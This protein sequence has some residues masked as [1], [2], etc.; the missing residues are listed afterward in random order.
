MGWEFYTSG[1][2]A[3]FLAVLPPRERVKLLGLFERMAAHPQVHSTDLPRVD[4]KGR[5]HWLRFGEGYA[6]IVWIDH[7]ERGLRIA[8]VG[9]E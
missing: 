4:A 8:E 7:A 6:V 3:K 2:V 9:F 1:H 5:R